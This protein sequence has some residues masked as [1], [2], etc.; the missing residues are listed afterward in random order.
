M[1]KLL[2]VGSAAYVKRSFVLMIIFFVS[3]IFLLKEANAV[4]E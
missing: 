1:P 3:S 2:A 4:D